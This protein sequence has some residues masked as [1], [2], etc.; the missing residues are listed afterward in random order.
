MYRILIVWLLAGAAHACTPGLPPL[1][2]TETTADHTVRRA[3]GP[4]WEWTEN[5]EDYWFAALRPLAGEVYDEVNDEFIRE[6]LW[7]LATRAQKNDR[8]QQRFLTYLHVDHDVTDPGSAS[9]RWLLPI[10]FDG[11]TAEGDTYRA[12]FPLGGKLL[13]FGSYDEVEFCLFPVYLRVE[14]GDRT[15]TSWFWPIFGK[16]DDPKVRKCRI[17]PLW[18]YSE[19]L[20]Q[21]RDNYLLWPLITWSRPLNDDIS[22]GG[23][24]CMPF[25]GRL[26]Y[27]EK[28]SKRSRDSIALLWPFF[29]RMKTETGTRWHC[30]WPFVT[31]ERDL[32]P[33]D[34]RKFAIW[35]LWGQRTDTDETRRFM[36]W[37]IAWFYGPGTGV[38]TA[39][40]RQSRR[41]YVLPVY[42]A[43]D[44]VNTDGS[45]EFY[46]RL[47]PLVS[48]AGSSDG[49]RRVRVLDLWPAREAPP[50]DRNW[51]PL[52]TLYQ[53]EASNDSRRHELLWGL[54]QY[55]RDGEST[56]SSLLGG[57]YGRER[58][59]DTSITRLLWFSFGD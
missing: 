14:K 39:G 16:V 24:F 44:Y 13:D 19:T 51:A 28:D 26:R 17:F 48:V 32:T 56:C 42:W 3:L 43:Y 41:L 9:S 4:F 18:G 30:P 50:V 29:S 55:R 12:C 52:W 22:G 31:I 47:W 8:R 37:P 21:W 54:W 36:F 49:T 2:Q 40:A 15:G 45:R 6:I 58:T 46:R 33:D 57:L 38:E 25:G 35:P 1:W 7:P 27:A 59:G 11:Q 53:H 5:K 20:G 23:F 34:D 10:Y